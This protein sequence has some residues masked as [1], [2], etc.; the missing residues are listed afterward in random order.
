MKLMFGILIGFSLFESLQISE[1]KWYSKEV[2][3]SDWR[4]TRR[5]DFSTNKIVSDYY[6][7]GHSKYFRNE[8][9]EEL[10]SRLDEGETLT[11]GTD[12][13][14][15]T[16]ISGQFLSESFIDKYWD[17]WENG[18]VIVFNISKV[19]NAVQFIEVH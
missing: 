18:E 13:Y 19:N 5:V 2:R 8:N 16:Q 11:L 9:M 1:M 7:G 14:C 6:A 17:R 3:F 15:L 4:N 12:Y 10:N